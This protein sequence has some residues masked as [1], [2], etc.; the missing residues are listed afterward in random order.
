MDHD[1]WRK[2][3]LRLISKMGI[4]K[5][6]REKIL[7]PKLEKQHKEVA[8]QQIKLEQQVKEV[9]KKL[10]ESQKE[11]NIDLGNY[12]EHLNQKLIMLIEISNEHITDIN[13]ISVQ[14]KTTFERAMASINSYTSM[15]EAYALKQS[16][17]KAI[18]LEKEERNVLFSSKDTYESTYNGNIRCEWQQFLDSSIIE[19]H[20]S[21]H[22]TKCL[23]NIQNR[24][25]HLALINDSTKRQLDQLLKL[26]AQKQKSIKKLS[27]EKKDKE[28]LFR[29]KEKIHKSNKALFSKSLSTSIILVNNLRKNI[30]RPTRELI[31]SIKPIEEDLRVQK[32]ISRTHWKT[33]KAAISDGNSSLSDST[34]VDITKTKNEISCIESRMKLKQN[35][36]DKSRQKSAD[37]LSVIDK[38]DP[39]KVML[40]MLSTTLAEMDKDFYRYAI[41]VKFNEK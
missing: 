23:K 27:S 5:W 9:E 33:H 17:I 25:K 4:I 14:L 21:P 16:I 8:R 1:K 20:S 22:V 11:R 13:E 28:M 2:L 12:Q 18:A 39:Y 35:I 3:T 29:D 10:K 31:E 40:P 6:F 7:S 24:E 34:Y 41:G 36:I 26:I 19:S 15:Q 38:L 30:K 32:E 37:I